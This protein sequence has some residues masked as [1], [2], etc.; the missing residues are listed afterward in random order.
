MKIAGR[1]LSIVLAGS[2]MVPT[3]AQ[4]GQYQR[5]VYKSTYQEEII[6]VGG[7]HHGRHYGR[8]HGRKHVHHHHHHHKRKGI[9]GGEALAIGVIGLAAGAIIAGA[10]NQPRHVAPPP[11]YHPPQPVYRAPVHTYRPQPWTSEWYS[12]CAS[13]YR[14]FNPSTGTF[15][16]YSGATRFCQ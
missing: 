11:A 14:S 2:L 13:K 15:T 16:A 4:A 3:I 7:R 5:T 10:A 6:K 12:Y 9:S 8:H 1:I